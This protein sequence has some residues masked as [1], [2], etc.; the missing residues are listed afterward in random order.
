MS[1]SGSRPNSKVARVIERYG[2]EGRGDELEAAWTGEYGERT[3]LR[4]L[5]EEFNVDVLA[6]ALRET[7]GTAID[8]DIESTYHTLTD[9]EVARADRMRK[10]RELEREGVEVDSVLSDFVTHQAIHTYLTEY[11]KA[12]LPDTSENLLERKIETIERLQGRTTAVTES[13]VDSLVNAG[14]ITDRNYEVLVDIRAVCTD[15]GTDYTL[16][17]LLRDGGCD[18]GTAD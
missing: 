5:A 18:C 8:S 7:G 10:R 11:R 15:C 2:M 1:D 3:S 4:D 14:E 16:S 6:A 17:D 12:E 13:S 9:D